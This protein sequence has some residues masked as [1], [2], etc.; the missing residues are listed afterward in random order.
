MYKLVAALVSEMGVQY[1]EL[2]RAQ[3]LITETLKLEETR[4]KETLDRGLRILQDEISGITSSGTLDGATAFK[5]YDT[6]G[7]PLDLTQDFMRGYGWQ[8]DLD[9]FDAAMQAQKVAARRA[10]SGSGDAAT[11][12]VWLDLGQRLEPT[13]CDSS[14]KCLPTARR[15]KFPRTDRLLIESCLAGSRSM[16]SGNGKLLPSENFPPTPRRKKL[17]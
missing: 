17:P 8:V 2:G 15:M 6:Y 11:E 16:T 14:W 12:S 4:F 10:W 3:S 5:L 1:S 13:E 7:F 9:G